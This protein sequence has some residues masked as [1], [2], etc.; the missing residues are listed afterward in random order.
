[1][2]KTLKVTK[3]WKTTLYNAKLLAAR[4][5]MTMVQL[6]HNLVMEKVEEVQAKQNEGK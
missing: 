5:D 2:D 3:L 6:I 1:M 4:F